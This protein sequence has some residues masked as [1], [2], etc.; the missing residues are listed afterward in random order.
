MSKQ[1]H[2]SASH[3][4]ASHNNESMNNTF[5]ILLN[6]ISNACRESIMFNRIS[7]MKIT[8]NALVAEIS[9]SKIGDVTVIKSVSKA[10]AAE[11]SKIVQSCIG[12]SGSVDVIVVQ[13]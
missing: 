5:R 11:V 9:T 2:H 7:T 3:V 6:T 12:K 4:I 13:S 1:T 10:D 8:K